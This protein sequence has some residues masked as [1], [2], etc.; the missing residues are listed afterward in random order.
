MTRQT[1]SQAV[2]FWDVHLFAQKRIDTVVDFP[3]IGSPAWCALPDMHPAKWAAVVDAA[4]HWALR[5]ETNQAAMAE[6]S[7]AVSA[8]VDW[9]AV[10]R[11]VQQRRSFRAERPWLQRVDS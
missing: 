7:R 10:S 9:S 4:Q 1:E 8:A 3:L 5:L 11:E 2:S 6:A